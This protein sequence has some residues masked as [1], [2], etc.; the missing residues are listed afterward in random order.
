MTGVTNLSLSLY[1]FSIWTDEHER[2]KFLMTERLSRNE[3]IHCIFNKILEFGT[4]KVDS[5]FMSQS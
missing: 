2:L 1:P 3:K 4:I 5:I